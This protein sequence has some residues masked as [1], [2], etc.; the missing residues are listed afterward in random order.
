MTTS[1]A[2]LELA[3][4]TNQRAWKLTTSRP[5][6]PRGMTGTGTAAG[7][8]DSGLGMFCKSAAVDGT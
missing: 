1:T 3:L 4:N 7:T 6:Q 2:T 5:N 8:V